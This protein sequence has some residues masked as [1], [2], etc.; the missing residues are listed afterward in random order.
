MADPT[1]TEALRAAGYGHRKP[2]PEESR[3]SYAHTIYRLGSG[4]VVGVMT[5]S[6]AWRWLRK[7]ASDER[8]A[9]S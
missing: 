7:R 1:L 9:G 6:E 8:E 3:H 4:E 5:A 2:T